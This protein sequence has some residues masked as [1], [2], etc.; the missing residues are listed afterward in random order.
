MNV[1][2]GA[3][4]EREK[5]VLRMF[6]EGRSQV[7]STDIGK[8]LGL[9][10]TTQRTRVMRSLEGKELVRTWQPEERDDNRPIAAPLHC[11][12]TPDGEWWIDEFGA[13]LIV[14]RKDV[15][16]KEECLKL[17]NRVED[18]ENELDDHKQFTQQN[19]DRL[20]DNLMVIDDNNRSLLKA[21]D[22]RLDELERLVDPEW[23][24][25]IKSIVSSVE[26]DL[27][28]VTARVDSNKEGIDSIDT[29][30]D[31]IDDLL[32]RVQSLEEFEGYAR[33]RLTVVNSYLTDKV[34]PV[35]SWYRDEVLT[36]KEDEEHNK[37]KLG[38]LR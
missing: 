9:D 14:E 38:F 15:D 19:V 11:E 30:A 32:T 22:E 31:D 4:S 24:V 34:S 10:H 33:Q 23:R 20:D 25:T 5:E 16:W 28:E 27:S 1:S 26:K 6:I 21:R 3:L 18:L 13:G 17:R 36:D 2:D 29:R 7:T 8:R 35:V 12:L 37:S